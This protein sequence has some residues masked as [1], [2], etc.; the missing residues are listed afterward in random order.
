MSYQI[1]SP[2]ELYAQLAQVYR[3]AATLEEQYALLRRVFG[4]AVQQR[5]HDCP[6]AFAGFFSK[7]DYLMKEC[8]VPYA[9]ADL[10]QQTRADLFPKQGDGHPQPTAQMLRAQ[11]DNNVKGTALLVHHTNGLAPIPLD[12][13]A[14]FP[15]EPRQ[16]TWGRYA[17]NVL[18]VITQRWD[19]DF[20]WATDEESGA[21]LQV[22]YS[23]A[24]PILTRGGEGDWGYL[25]EVLWEG[26]VLHLVRVRRDQSGQVCLPE[27]IILEPDYLVNITTIARCFETYAESPRVAL[28]D[29]LRPA[30][31][32]YHIH[33]GNLAGQL[34]DDV[35]H[36]RHQ[37][38]G[39]CL[40]TYVADHALSMMACPELVRDYELF[41]EE[42]AAQQ[43]N[44]QQLIGQRL[45]EAIGHYDRRDVLLEPS[46][47]SSVLGIQGRLDFLYTHE[48]GVT[49]IEQKSGKGDYVS[50]RAPGYNPAV[51]RDR[52]SV[53]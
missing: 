41:R 34:L 19:D 16:R 39:E 2:E 47:F 20:I 49:I 17:H 30:A 7:V 21:T 42:A 5:L 18:R 1:T 35:V 46:F 8:R 28:V 36:D 43:R 11:L 31:N 13:Q 4:I 29:K 9:A 44:I 33:L 37:P 26:A 38:I 32:S 45:P 10:I 14:H 6:I 15:T 50:P 25:R 23:A 40:K 48:D 52:K 51:P 12:L 24:N 27:L 53:V 3:T 22:C